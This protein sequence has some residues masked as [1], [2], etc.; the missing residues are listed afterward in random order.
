MSILTH[1]CPGVVLVYGDE[2]HV[3]RAL[4][5]VYTR[6][7]KGERL[8]RVGDCPKRSDRM[9]AYGAYDFTNGGCLPW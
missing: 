1:S 8:W 7:R 5:L 6:G 9:N 4:D 3:H 2:V